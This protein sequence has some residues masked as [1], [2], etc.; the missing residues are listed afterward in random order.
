MGRLGLFLRILVMVL[1]R[2]TVI[3]GRRCGIVV[4]WSLLITCLSRLKLDG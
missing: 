1:V 4:T 3:L 2:L